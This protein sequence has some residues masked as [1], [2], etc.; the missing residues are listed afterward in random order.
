MNQRKRG[1]NESTE[2]P[3]GVAPDSHGIEH[4][5]ADAAADDPGQRVAKPSEIEIFEQIA[6]DIAANRSPAQAGR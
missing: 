2:P 5:S 4:L 3:A 6:D 1:A